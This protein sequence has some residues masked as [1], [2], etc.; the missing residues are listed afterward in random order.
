MEKGPEQKNSI[1][2]MFAPY[3]SEKRGDLLKYLK[4]C[5]ENSADNLFRGPEHLKQIID[6]GLVSPGFTVIRV[7][8]SPA[9][10]STYFINKENLLESSG[11]G[12]YNMSA[13]SAPK[14]TYKPEKILK[15]RNWSILGLRFSNMEK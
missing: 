5:D 13:V 7:D 14:G 4:S 10:D 15:N 6:L 9:P 1:Y 8:N 11:Q 12:E 3:S 2:N